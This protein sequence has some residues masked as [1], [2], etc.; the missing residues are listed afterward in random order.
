M[1]YSN[2]YIIKQDN[3]EETAG[4]ELRLL[5]LIADGDNVAFTE[6]YHQYSQPLYNYL[7]RLTHDQHATE[8]ILQEIFVAIWKGARSYRGDAQVKTWIYRIAHNQAVN[9]LRRHR[10]NVS[11]DDYLDT[12]DVRGSEDIQNNFLRK[13]QIQQALDSLSYKHRSVLELAFVHQMSYK[14]I[15]RVVRVPVGTVKSRM[16]YALQALNK[17]LRNM[18]SDL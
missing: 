13:Y 14:E 2:D 5:G 6:L 3:Q 9:W 7:L 12:L 1:A 17:I 4:T 11:F 18:E 8:D 15:S 16:S 10:S